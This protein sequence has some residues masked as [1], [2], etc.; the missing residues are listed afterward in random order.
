MT[1]GSS[2]DNTSSVREQRELKPNGHSKKKMHGEEFDYA[3]CFIH[4]NR[5]ILTT[6]GW[7]LGIY[8]TLS[9]CNAS[10]CILHSKSSSASATQWTAGLASCDGSEEDKQYHNILAVSFAMV[11]HGLAPKHRARHDSA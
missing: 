11:Y 4:F 2:D 10:Q 1:I 8:L 9:R 7:V 6:C 3:I 5:E